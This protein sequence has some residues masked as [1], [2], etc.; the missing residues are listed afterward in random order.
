MVKTLRHLT[1]DACDRS[2]HFNMTRFE[3][4]GIH[5]RIRQRALRQARAR[6]RDNPRGYRE[7]EQEDLSA[8]RQTVL[9]EYRDERDLHIYTDGS[10]LQH[11]RR[12]GAGIVFVT[13]DDDGEEQV[14]TYP[15]FGFEGATNQ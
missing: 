14:D 3:L 7:A 13:V 6:N 9:M 8:L 11:P 12:G 1:D 4:R 2:S 15:V 10:S 5:D